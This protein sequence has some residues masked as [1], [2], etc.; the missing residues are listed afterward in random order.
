MRSFDAFA[1]SHPLAAPYRAQFLAAWCYRELSIDVVEHC[2]RVKGGDGSARFGAEWAR[3][4]GLGNATGLGLVPYAFKHPRIINAWVGVR[5]LALARVR[6]S[7][8]SP[9]R[10]AQLRSWFERAET[11]Y[12]T[13]TV[14]D[15]EPFLS[16][17]ELVPLVREVR[18][19]VEELAEHSHPNAFD[20]LVTWAMARHVEL[21]ELVVSALV[22]L[23]ELNDE[24][25][26]ELLTVDESVEIDFSLSMADAARLLTERFGWA[27]KEPVEAMNWWVY[28]DNTE[29]PRRL[30][31]T[32][33]PD[34]SQDM[35]IDI[36]GNMRALATEMESRPSEMTLGELLIDAP[37]Y[38]Q[39]IERLFE[40]DQPYGEPRD[41]PCSDSYLPLQVQRLQLAQYGMD[42]FKPKS[43]DW[44]RVTL[45][46]GAPRLRDLNAED[47]HDRWMMPPLPAS[48]PLEAN[49]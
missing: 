32:Y 6:T 17:A 43:T 45:F 25:V 49:G 5:E 35:A 44:L 37:E 3:F 33:W 34:H 48:E 13:G 24:L 1:D 16:P 28:S 40:S 23:D 19:V 36:A 31:R 4:F 47:F 39:A 38:L 2:A 30:P 26:D 9:E 29:E 20:E 42:N 27:L 14:E 22:D 11:H 10:W 15:A 8:P 41:N 7:G 46:Q 12:A 18:D 21:G